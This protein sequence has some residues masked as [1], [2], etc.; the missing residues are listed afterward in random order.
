MIF[1]LA[2]WKLD[3]SAYPQ[4]CWPPWSTPVSIPSFPQ[5]KIPSSVLLCWVRCCYSAFFSLL[6][7][8]VCAVIFIYSIGYISDQ[9]GKYYVICS[10][11]IYLVLSQHKKR[12]GIVLHWYTSTRVCVCVYARVS[13]EKVGFLIFSVY[14]KY[15]ESVSLTHRCRM[16]K[17][18]PITFFVYIGNRYSSA[19]IDAGKKSVW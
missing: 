13:L 17:I 7:T 6:C 1:R 14:T 5:V 12:K 16:N 15:P 9:A 2:G 11:V 4:R 3:G 19:M 8:Y 10:P 18:S